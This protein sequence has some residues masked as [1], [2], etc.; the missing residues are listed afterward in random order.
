M[1]AHYNAFVSYSHAA[2]GL[3]APRLQAALQ[4]FARP[5]HRRRALEVFRDETGLSANPGLWSSIAAALDDSEWFVLLASPEAAQSRWVNREIEQWC[6]AGGAGRILPV[7]TDGEWVWDTETGDFD[8]ARSTAVPAALLGAFT[9]EPR[10]VDM[11]W[12]RS[13]TQLDLHNGRFRDQVAEI[14][15]PMHGLAKDELTGADVRQHRRTRRLASAAVVGLL[16]LLAASVVGAVTALQQAAAAQSSEQSALD[17]QSD[18]E[19]AARRAVESKAEAEAAAERQRQADEAAAEAERRRADAEREGRSKSEAAAQVAESE[20]AKAEASEAEAVRRRA[21]ADRQRGLAEASAAEALAQ[22]AEATASA[23]IARL[24]KA[25]AELAAARAEEAAARARVQRGKAVRSEAKAER[26]AKELRASQRKLEDEVKARAAANT[27]L[28]GRGLVALA[29]RERALG[30]H[31]RAVLLLAEAART[32]GARTSMRRELAATVLGAEH[33]RYLPGSAAGGD[34][35]TGPGRVATGGAAATSQGAQVWDLAAPQKAPV[36]LVGTAGGG[37]AISGALGRNQALSAEGPPVGPGPPP[38]GPDRCQ[39]S[40]GPEEPPVPEVFRQ[41]DLNGFDATGTRIVGVPRDQGAVQV[42]DTRTGELLLRIGSAAFGTSPPAVAFTPD[43]THVLVQVHDRD[44][45]SC[46]VAAVDLRHA[47]VVN[48]WTGLLRSSLG[49]TAGY[50]RAADAAD[51]GPD[52]RH[53]LYYD[54]EAGS[55]ALADLFGGS[56]APLL[57]TDRFMIPR[58]DAGGRRVVGLVTPTLL[59]EW[60]ASTGTIVSTQ[61]LE[62]EEG[63][64]AVRAIAAG[65]H[66][67]AAI[68]SDGRLR[69][70]RRDDGRQVWSTEGALCPTGGAI[71]LSPHE[72]RVVVDCLSSDDPSAPPGPPGEAPPVPRRGVFVPIADAADDE[73]FVLEGLG[74]ITDL[75]DG[76]GGQGAGRLPGAGL[77]RSHP[78]PR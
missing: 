66:V 24:R 47:S 63:V 10:H 71:D 25:E 36:V 32:G 64:V 54:T 45:G 51:I 13:E 3:L 16:V 15:A 20:R 73:E 53:F 9:E 28:D 39:V 1:S 60:E 30:N 27:E 8:W 77:V 4:G 72:T 29:Q 69:T 58:F 34:I 78:V 42:W 26:R 67:A 46:S 33:L 49:F 14:A 18:A 21:E 50:E 17:A 62:D 75:V 37:A 23:D 22:R 19:Q 61:T 7:V 43:R 12:A 35:V 48:T 11:R 59:A 76:P 65:R 41:V 74:P 38:P 56:S 2:D 57:S 5:W 70:F 52:G 44:N 55:W 31:D 40:T 68:D 6:R